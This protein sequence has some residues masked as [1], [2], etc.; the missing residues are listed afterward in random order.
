MRVTAIVSA[1]APRD[2]EDV[3]TVEIHLDVTSTLFVATHLFD[4]DKLV[5]V[6]DAESRPWSA[7]PLFRRARLC[8]PHNELV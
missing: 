6:A 5:F 1:Q 4:S 2:H 3:E 8:R 7:T